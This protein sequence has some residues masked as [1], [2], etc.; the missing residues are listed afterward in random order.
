MNIQTLST[1]SILEQ[2]VQNIETLNILLEPTI[3]DV[4][5]DMI[6]SLWKDGKQYLIPL[7]HHEMMYNKLHVK[8]IPNLPSTYWID[9]ENNLHDEFNVNNCVFGII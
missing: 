3:N 2:T 6:Y 9:E 7:W 8:I 4:M 5:E 1:K